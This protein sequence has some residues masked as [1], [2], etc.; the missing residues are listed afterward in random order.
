MTRTE[1]RALWSAALSQFGAQPLEQ[2]V[3][4]YLGQLLDELGEQRPSQVSAEDL[5]QLVGVL[6][7]DI[8]AG[9]RPMFEPL[10]AMNPQHLHVLRQ[11]HG[12]LALSLLADLPAALVPRA[13]LGLKVEANVGL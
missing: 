10:R 6:L 4:V 8:E 3:L 5:A 9:E 11:L 12:Q 7:S 2:R 1:I 13:L